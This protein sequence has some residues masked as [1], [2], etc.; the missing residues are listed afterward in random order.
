MNQGTGN[1]EE[2][3]RQ[4]RRVII[5]LAATALFL[6]GSAAG[7]LAWYYDYGTAYSQMISPLH[8]DEQLEWMVPS[9]FWQGMP[10]TEVEQY[11]EVGFLVPDAE[12]SAP[13]SLVGLIHDMRKW[14]RPRHP[15]AIRI[16]I[17]FDESD[18][19]NDVQWSRV[20]EAR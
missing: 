2:T 16:A 6:L 9:V 14:F 5:A 13:S 18:T 1:S 8:E 7:G 4:E 11:V 15:E 20:N 3:R 12:A 10:R 17:D 19:V